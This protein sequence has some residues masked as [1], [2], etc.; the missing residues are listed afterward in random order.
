MTYFKGSLG[1]LVGI[2]VKYD[3]EREDWKE[4]SIVRCIHCS[5]KRLGFV[6]NI[7]VR[8]LPVPFSSSSRYSILVSGCSVHVY[9]CTLTHTY[10]Y[11][12]K[13]LE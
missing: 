2:L 7:H 13:E 1:V 12:N 3:W 8:R 5:C 9:T 10:T 4:G 11:T 6:L